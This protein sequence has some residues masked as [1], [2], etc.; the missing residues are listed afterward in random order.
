V[1]VAMGRY[2]DALKYYNKVIELAPN[3]AGVYSNIGFVYS[4]L[5][6]R[7][8]AIGS[9]KRAIEI[10]RDFSLAHMVLARIYLE[11]GQKDLA[12]EYYEKSVSLGQPR[13]PE[14]EAMLK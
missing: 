2:E 4:L 8:D 12:R 3:N 7:E 6:R 13:E 5:G 10:N 11:G 14:F 1:S 9:L